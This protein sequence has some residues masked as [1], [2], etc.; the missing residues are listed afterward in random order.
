MRSNYFSVLILLIALFLP[1]KLVVASELIEPNSKPVPPQLVVQVPLAN[2]QQATITAIEI[3]E[4][5]VEQIT[6][7][8]KSKETQSSDILISTD[9][10]EVLEKVVEITSRPQD[11]R[12]L[13]FIPIGKL[14]SAS[15]KLAA[16]FNTYYQNAKHTLQHDRIGLTV[17]SITV[18][19]DTMLWIHS[20]SFDIHQKTSMVLM[21]LIMAATFGLDRD[22]WTKI[23]SP[24]KYKLINVF[25]KFISTEKLSTVKILTSQYLSNM[26]FGI[27]VQGLRIGL[28]S[29]DHI[30]EA[31]MSTNFWMSAAKIAG[32]ITLTTFAWTE[33]YGSIQNEKNPVAKLMMKRIGEMRGIILCQLASISMVLQP[34]VYGQVPIITYVIHGS[35]GLL[36]LANSER[37]INFLETNTFVTKIYKKIQT[38]ENFINDGIGIKSKKS[39]VRTCNSLFAN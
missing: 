18:G 4:S 5:S 26:I 14:A 35:I 3:P 6:E 15:Q 30:N 33:F 28:L 25:D 29:L 9:Q 17:L 7:I 8:L 24:L 37:I 2:G 11:K 23:T 21:N 34:H 32:L 1:L 12:L 27:G 22:L 31:L 36:V 10:E 16:G 19:Y 20:T 13:R 38:F 39:V